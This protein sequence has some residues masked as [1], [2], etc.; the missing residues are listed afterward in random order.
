MAKAIRELRYATI[1]LNTGGIIYKGTPLAASIKDFVH[2][3]REG[4]PEVYGGQESD[5]TGGQGKQD[6]ALAKSRN[7]YGSA[8]IKRFLL[9]N[10]AAQ[11]QGGEGRGLVLAK[12]GELFPLVEQYDG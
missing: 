10:T 2:G 8:S 7:L 3:L 5:I 6:P 1:D 4:R 12:L 9:S 11:Y